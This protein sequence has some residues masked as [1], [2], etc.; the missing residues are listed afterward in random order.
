VEKA[1]AV[2][3]RAQRRDLAKW[4][5]QREEAEREEE[6]CLRQ[7]AEMEM[8][9]AVLR[10]S[11]GLESAPPGTDQLDNTRFRS[12]TISQS[13]MD[14]M[15]SGG[16]RAKVADIAKALMSA[17]KLKNKRNAYSTVVKTLDR[18]AR[19]ERVGVGEFALVEPVRLI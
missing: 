8:A 9:I 4:Q 11:I 16:G 14:M 19:F 5:T 12:Q 10:R 7:I 6:A 1:L 2:K 13:C 15:R 18:D 3:I 17:G